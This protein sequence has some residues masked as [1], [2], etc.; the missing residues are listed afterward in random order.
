MEQKKEYNK[1]EKNI[2]DLMMEQFKKL[3]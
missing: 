1:M 2:P 3:I